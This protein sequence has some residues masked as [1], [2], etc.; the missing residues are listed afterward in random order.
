MEHAHSAHEF[1]SNPLT[2]RVFGMR[3]GY[4]AN[5]AI[6]LLRWRSGSVAATGG[7]CRP[8]RNGKS[9]PAI[10]TLGLADGQ[11]PCAAAVRSLKRCDAGAP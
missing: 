10:A 5:Y 2:L 1:S 4:Y 9:W 8:A 6:D 7:S 11:Q 3:A